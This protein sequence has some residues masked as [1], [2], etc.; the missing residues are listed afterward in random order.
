MWPVSEGE[1]VF[2]MI[3]TGTMIIL[4]LLSIWDLWK[5]QLPLILLICLLLLAIMHVCQVSGWEKWI[6]LE[7]AAVIG[8]CS[9][10]CAKKNKMGSGD[11]WVLSSLACI[12][13][14]DIY[15][16]V[17]VTGGCIL[18]M[19]AGMIWWH[20]QKSD[21]PVPMIPFLLLGYCIRGIL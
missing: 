16:K 11:V 2:F 20:T 3:Q 17:I 1:W 7:T 4:I 8:I 13:S 5:K 6:T 12:W 19:T 9:G 15:W 14:F 10:I 21:T 18:C